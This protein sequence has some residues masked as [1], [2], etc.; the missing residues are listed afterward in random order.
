MTGRIV[1]RGARTHNLRG[2]NVEIPRDR[3][4]VVTGPSGSGK[5][6]LAFNTVYAEGRRRYVESLSVYARQQLGSLGRPEVELIEGLSP[7]I[8]IE[9]RALGR[10]PRSTVGTVTEL[11]D[12][13]RLLLARAGV[14]SCPRCA[15]PVKAHTISEIV[16]AVLSLGEGA[17]AS[18]LAPAVRAERG[19]HDRLLSAWRREGFVRVRIDGELR[20]LGDVEALDPKVPHTVELVVDR[21]AVKE[22]AR[23]RVLDAVEIALKQAQG[24]VRI[25]PVSGDELLFSERFACAECGVTLPEIE[26]QLF[27]FNSPKGACA[28]CHGLGVRTV[29]DVSKLVPDGGRSLRAGAIQAFRKGLPREIEQWARGMGVDLD[30]PFDAL[31]ER[32]REELL[33]G[34]G[35]EYPG[36]L[37]LIERAAR[38]RARSRDDEDD[39]DPP[40]G[41]IERYR[42]E[43]ACDACA[44]KRLRPEALC[45]RVGGFNV[46][47]LAQRPV[48]SLARDIAEIEHALEPKIRSVVERLL[49]EIRSR[50]AFL[51]SVG[52]PYLTLARPVATLS[53][54]EAQRVRLATQIGSSLVGVLYVLDEPSVGL[55]PRDSAQ[56]LATLRGLVHRGNSVLMV[57]HDLDLVRAADHVVD[58][59]PGAGV[60]GGLVVAE[61]PP[62]A[63]LTAPESVTGPYLS[64]ARAI[65]TPKQRR[66]AQGHVVVRGARLHNLRGGTARFPL[67]C[68]VAVTGVSGSGKSSLVLGTLLPAARAHLLRDSTREIAATSVE[69]LDAFDRVVAVDA[70]PIGRTPRSSPATYTGVFAQLRELFAGVPEARA[71]GFKPGR[72]SFNV[73]GGRCEACQGEGVLR[74]EMHFLPDVMVPCEACGGSRYERETLSVKYRGFSIADVLAMSVE[75]AYPHFE[76]VPKVRDALAALREVGLGYVKL[77]QPGTTLSGGEAQRI[78][79][80]RELSRRATGRTLYV[81]DEP[82]SGLHLRDI[83]VL[84]SLIDRLVDQGNTVVLIEHNMDVVKR[85]DWV[86]DVGPEGGEGGGHILCEGPPEVVARHGSSLTAGPLAAALAG[87]SALDPARAKG[88]L[89]REGGDRSQ[90]V[91]AAGSRAATLAPSAPKPQRAVKGSAKEKPAAKRAASA[92][93]ATAKRSPGGSMASGKGGRGRT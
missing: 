63:L 80:A 25:A 76:S 67:G 55:H 73:K 74:V 13:L 81:L 46:F 77:G 57:E 79:L 20:E 8:A 45:V 50:L 83:E 31:S 30:A 88:S 39:E 40:D 82:T 9:Q 7:A 90:R 54:G 78:K 87:R 14:A 58:M 66:A 65:A 91:D 42:V 41:V 5:S 11:D 71:R 75:E 84:V 64:G 85:A 22:G 44:G 48:R 33:H 93:S 10:N 62:D 35:D 4:V 47:E 27:S 29:A 70:T 26:P 69:G 15:K 72:F 49:V 68:L 32:A 61:G 2:V 60:R 6:S 51:Q 19:A 59:G 16:D 23:A 37:A 1:V 28:A 17:R 34:D 18:I 12:Y 53:G 36:A 86:I 43:A 52:L 89:A 3:L 56:L 21:V 24:L 38:A 92:A